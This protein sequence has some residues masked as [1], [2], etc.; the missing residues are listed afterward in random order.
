MKLITLTIVSLLSCYTCFAFGELEPKTNK[1]ET[2]ELCYVFIRAPHYSIDASDINLY[3]QIVEIDK[4][5]YSIQKDDF[6]EQFGEIV[7]EL[8]PDII[9]ELDYS[10]LQFFETAA[11]A[12]DFRSKSITDDTT[13]NLEIM[14]VEILLLGEEMYSVK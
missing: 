12:K 4:S 11:A 5:K 6:M 1:S 10:C 7:S 9:C 3:S 14:D 8:Y 2:K 13:K